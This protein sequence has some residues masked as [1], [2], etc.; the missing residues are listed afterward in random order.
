MSGLEAMPALAI[1]IVLGAEQ[2]PHPNLLPPRGRRSVK[3][4][5]LTNAPGT[6][7]PSPPSGERAGVRGKESYARSARP[8][9]GLR[10][11]IVSP[12]S[13]PR[14]PAQGFCC[15]ASSL[16]FPA[17]E[18]LTPGNDTMNAGE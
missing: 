18:R 11:R 12:R 8:E 16:A 1:G 15:V 14:H 5:P 17:A 9:F 3:H 13:S 7:A 10:P 6:P 2:P 4:A